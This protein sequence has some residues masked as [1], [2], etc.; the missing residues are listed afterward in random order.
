MQDIFFID[1]Y[2]FSQAPQGCS[3]NI[4][5]NS[6]ITGMGMIVICKKYLKRKN[7]GNQGV[8]RVCRK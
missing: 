8:R 7:G 3:K 4:N 5:I 6:L 1:R 2:F